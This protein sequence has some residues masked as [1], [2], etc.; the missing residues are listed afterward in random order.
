MEKD[1]A[2]K[3]MVHCV[4]FETNALLRTLDIRKESFTFWNLK[5]LMFLFGYHSL[6]RM[7][8]KKSSN[9]D[10]PFRGQIESIKL[11]D[12][13]SISVAPTL[14]I[15]FSFLRSFRLSKN[16][17]YIHCHHRSKAFGDVLQNGK[18]PVFVWA[19]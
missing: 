12:N 9:T 1:S 13:R 17:I 11:K 15:L 16:G 14:D 7:H 10:A 3:E 5:S 18:V 6:D 4:T 19:K 8:D 2:L